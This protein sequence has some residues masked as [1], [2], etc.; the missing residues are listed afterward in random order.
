MSDKTRGE[1][2]I[3]RN[4]VEFTRQ[5]DWFDPLDSKHQIQT[6]IVGCGGV[7]SPTALALS[8]MGVPYLTL[9]DDD[10]IEN[11]NIPNQLFPV[12]LVGTAKVVALTAVVSMFGT[13]EVTYAQKKVQEVPDL[14]SGIVITG[15]DSMEARA[16]V[17]KLVRLNQ[18]VK[19]LID[20]RMGGMGLVVWCIDP[21]NTDHIDMYEKHAMYSDSEAEEAPCTARA[22]ID[23]GFQIASLNTRLVRMVMK[24]EEVPP[25]IGFNQ[26]SYT[27]TK[28]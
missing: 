4:E 6:V 3:D 16:E 10:V 17:W 12:K 19:Y 11:H 1:E 9:I 15:L 20:A 8:K 7:G 18:K 2:L 21:N 25:A 13:S 28:F 27:V 14:L 5:L 24:G 26:E 23:V 22:V